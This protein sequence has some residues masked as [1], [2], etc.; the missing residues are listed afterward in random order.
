MKKK[1]NIKKILFWTGISLLGLLILVI[2]IVNLTP[3]PVAMVVR[4]QFE[5]GI[6][7]KPSDYNYYLDKVKAIKDLEYPSLYKDNQT[8]LYLPKTGEN[9][10]LIIWVH[11]GAFVGGDKKDVTEYATVLAAHGYAVLSINYERA[12]KLKY[13]NQLKQVYEAYSWFVGVAADYNVDINNLVF[14]GDSAGAFMVAQIAV[15][16]TSKEYADLMNFEQLILADS[17]KGLLLYCGPYNVD[18][19]SETKNI[20]ASFLFSQIAW[21]YFGDRNW[22][23]KYGEI[24]TI[25]NHITEYYPP[26]FITDGNE[27]SFESHAKELE[28]T[29]KDK[30]VLVE[31]LYITDEKAGHEYQFKLDTSA[32]MKSIEETLKF[33]DIVLER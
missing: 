5:K 14:A 9:F 26:T 12:P 19:I 20:A 1:V 4:S 23:E 33:L 16:E 18:K 21:A 7:T 32:G 31:S 2:I 11:G 10:P 15:I 25:K 6:A 30:N 29:L 8:D 17:L 28:N 24:A 27:F 3:V 13:P 22:V